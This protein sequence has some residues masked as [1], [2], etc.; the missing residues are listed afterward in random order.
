MSSPKVSVK[1][2]KLS[3]TLAE[4]TVPTSAQAP[5]KKQPPTERDQLAMAKALRTKRKLPELA[6]DVSEDEE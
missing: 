1:V 5:V 2:G 3:R 6:V 4:T